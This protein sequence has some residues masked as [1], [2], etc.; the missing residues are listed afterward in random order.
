MF[1]LIPHFAHLHGE[2]DHGLIEWNY[3]TWLNL[4]GILLGLVLLFVRSRTLVAQK[5]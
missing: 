1:N 4:G 2:M 5:L 3:T